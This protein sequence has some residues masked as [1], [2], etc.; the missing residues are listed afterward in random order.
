MSDQGFDLSSILSNWNWSAMK[1]IAYDGCNCK[2]G[3][4][5]SVVLFIADGG[6]NCDRVSV[7]SVELFINNIRCNCDRES[8]WSVGLFIDN[9]GCNYDV[10][11]E[12][13]MP[14]LLLQFLHLINFAFSVGSGL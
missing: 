9:G 10:D 1:L 3:S 2:R 8:M 13:Q 4:M 5:R 7:W 6:C 11:P 12:L 14:R